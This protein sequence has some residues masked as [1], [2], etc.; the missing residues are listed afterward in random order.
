MNTWGEYFMEKL[1]DISDVFTS[2]IDAGAMKK[3]LVA[4]QS[5]PIGRLMVKMY[6]FFSTNTGLYLGVLCTVVILAYF[7]V[8]HD[9]YYKYNIFLII[10]YCLLFFKIVFYA[11]TCGVISSLITK[12]QS[13]DKSMHYNVLY[14]YGIVGL[15]VELLMLGLLQDLL[16]FDRKPRSTFSLKNL[17][18]FF[19]IVAN[20]VFCGYFLSTPNIINTE[21]RNFVIIFLILQLFLFYVLPFIVYFLIMVNNF[22]ENVLSNYVYPAIAN[23]LFTSKPGSKQERTHVVALS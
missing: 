10:G 7:L 12:G 2:A 5:E 23:L 19:C 22:V 9:N 8:N 20:V 14:L 21:E 16:L 1:D 17:F 11:F 6:M 15:F 4:L 13:T 18:M 3:V